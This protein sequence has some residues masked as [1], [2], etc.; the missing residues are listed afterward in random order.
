[1]AKK[2]GL[3]PYAKSSPSGLAANDLPGKS[4]HH[5]LAFT[6]ASKQGFGLEEARKI[7]RSS[8]DVDIRYAPEQN[9]RNYW[10]HFDPLG[11]LPFRRDSRD[12]Y[13][14]CYLKLAVETGDVY[15]LGMGLHSLQDKF[16][17][18]LIPF[19]KDLPIL[20]RFIGTWRDNPELN[21]R[22]FAKAEN[23]AHAYLRRFLEKSGN[24]QT[25]D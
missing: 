19:Q 13:A 8:Q 17:H 10:R 12:S 15:Y 24:K 23:A 7:A 18:G 11:W 3:H 21:P 2:N 16:E 9:I 4:T 25:G 22:A 14:D 1:M 5:Q 6:I 20:K